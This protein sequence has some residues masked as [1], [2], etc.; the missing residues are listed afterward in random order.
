MKGKSE[1]QAEE[2]R[3][4]RGTGSSQSLEAAYKSASIVS[5]EVDRHLLP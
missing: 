3:G 2:R 1:G 4:R 5:L